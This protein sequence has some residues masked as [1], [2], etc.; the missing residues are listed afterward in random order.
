MARSVDPDLAGDERPLREPQAF[1]PDGPAALPGDRVELRVWVKLFRKLP[2]TVVYVPGI[3]KRR[4]EMEHGGLTW[5]GIRLDDD[6]TV[7]G[8][9]VDPATRRMKKGVRFL[10][11]GEPQELAAD[12]E[13][14]G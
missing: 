12:V 14:E 8:W 7:V 11:R 4:G 3:S 5:V 10:G 6:G 2:G 9:F 1:Y 13:L